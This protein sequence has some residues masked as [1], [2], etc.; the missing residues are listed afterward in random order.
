MTES[1][2]ASA[3]AAAAIAHEA[4]QKRAADF[5]EPQGKRACAS[6][7]VPPERVVLLIN[8]TT[9]DSRFDNV[10]MVPRT[11]VTDE[12]WAFA[13][14]A[15]QF[16]HERGAD[17]DD[18]QKKRAF[19]AD[20]YATFKR[21]VRLTRLAQNVDKENIKNVPSRLPGAFPHALTNAY[22]AHEILLIEND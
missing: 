21:L 4:T 19:F 15:Q 5:A 14:S 12:E 18:E 10:Y 22:V 17:K 6:I 1:S 7:S 16:G 8:T 11:S 13:L 9:M 2:V 20:D 3:A